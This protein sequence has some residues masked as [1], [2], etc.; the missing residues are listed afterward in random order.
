MTLVAGGIPVGIVYWLHKRYELPARLLAVGLL[1][2]S[3]SFA[4]QT[5]VILIFDGP[6]LNSPLFGSMLLAIV[7][8][9]TDIGARF[10]AY[11]T[12]ARGVVYRPQA[13]LIGI[14]HGMPRM[15]FNAG[16]FL[17][18][19]VEW[20]SV[21][22]IVVNAG[23]LWFHVVMSWMVLQTF[24]RNEIGWTFQAVFLTG[25]A[26]GTEALIANIAN[27]PNTILMIW[28]IG[29]ALIGW[30]LY[31]RLRPP[32]AFVWPTAQP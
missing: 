13:A 22:E 11:Q 18:V 30:R 4:I 17:M 20:Q 2:Y 23:Q 15:I 28:W 10:W 31:Q 25:F 16:L 29:V 26:F 6:L 14:G 19:T 32:A 1:T 12:I 5:I 9:F 8:G 27:E 24:L 3:G 21:V 7:I